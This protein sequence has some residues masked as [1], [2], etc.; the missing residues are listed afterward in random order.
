[1]SIIRVRPKDLDLR[2]M[3]VWQI[4]VPLIERS[5]DYRIV[6]PQSFHQEVAR[7]LKGLLIA[8]SKPRDE[9]S[10]PERRLVLRYWATASTLA[11]GQKP[12]L[13]RDNLSA[14][15]H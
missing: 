5:L 10:Q 7:D 9:R 3:P 2:V 1:M 4:V 12:A 6:N 14:G 8:V 15:T 13:S 11:H